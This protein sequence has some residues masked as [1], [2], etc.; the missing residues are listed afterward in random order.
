MTVIF[1]SASGVTMMAL[2]PPNSKMLRPNRS[3]TAA[4]TL[5]PMAV[6]PV[7]EIK[8]I[9]ESEVIH[10]P[11]SAVPVTMVLIPSGRLLAVATWFHKYWHATAHKGAFSEAFHT[12][13]SP[14]TQARA[15]FQLHTAT[16]KLKALMTPTM[17]NGCHCSIMWWLGRSLW[18]VRPVNCRDKPTA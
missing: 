6:D 11:T 2:L 9:L 18:M 14:H 5:R 10:W 12:T 3:A 7:A 17:P 15:A 4:P 1:K 13:T 8:G 16:G